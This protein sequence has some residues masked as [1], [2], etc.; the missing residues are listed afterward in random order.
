MT[1]RF[2]LSVGFLLL[3]S[4]L[5]AAGDELHDLLVNRVDQSRR[6]A[7]IVAGVIDANGRHVTAAG[8]L[9]L[10]RPGA[11][12]GDTIFEIG[13]T[14]KVFTSLILADMVERGE[15]KLDTPVADLLPAG[16]KFPS[17]GGR[18]I[19]LLDLSMHISGL[20]RMPNNMSPKDMSNIYADYTPAKLFQFLSG[21]TLTR[22]IGEKYEYSNLGGGLLG[23][24]LARKAGMTYEELVRK[25]ILEPLEM[26]DSG[27]P[28]STDQKIRMASGYDPGL[29]PVSNWEF[30]ALAGCGALRST[31]NDMLKFLAANLE[32]TDTPLKAAMRR[33]RSIRHE[34]GKDDV[35][36]MMA[37]NVY[38]KYGREIVWHDGSTAGYWSFLAFDAQKKTGIV[39]LA[40]TYLD[41][42][43]IGLH[44]LD[45]QW[46]AKE[47][48]PRKQYKEIQ[49]DPKILTS[50]VG[51]YR[52][53][54][55]LTLKV[56]VENGHMYAQS[57]TMPRFEM[58]AWAEGFFFIKTFE[59]EVS[60]VQDK[61]KTTSMYIS[62]KDGKTMKG[63][64]VH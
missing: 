40:N 35:E 24:A 8:R 12:D 30:D 51:E 14:T 5:H 15:V 43:D 29:Q 25:R 17:K 52:F 9:S 47:L 4:S 13:S 56:V 38:K 1:Q 44:T 41:V 53:N 58:F 54:G 64:K 62:L 36:V 10:D 19:S 7:G 37:W 46:P 31:A 26:N 18:N 63:E 49:L 27:I 42:D 3:A 34:T 23:F 28:L 45:K 20:P 55:N 32:L 61:G 57:S 59:A 2:T 48:E 50:Y 21:Y 33:M 39:L 6:A 60:F 16:M 11:V 22:N